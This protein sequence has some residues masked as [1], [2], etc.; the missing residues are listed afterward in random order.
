ML[1]QLRFYALILWRRDGAIPALVQLL[2]LKNRDIVREAPTAADLEHT[3]IKIL[4]L[5]DSITQMIGHGHFPPA[6]SPL[7]GWCAF[8]EFCPTFGGSPPVFP[9]DAAATLGLN[10]TTDIDTTGA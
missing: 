5:W 10:P 1:F 7:C 4:T 8:K 2:F 3:E 6:K 9:P